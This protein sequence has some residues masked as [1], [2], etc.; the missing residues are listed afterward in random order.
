MFKK[1][2]QDGT[3]LKQWGVY[4]VFVAAAADA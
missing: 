4:T 1:H 2:P 3:D